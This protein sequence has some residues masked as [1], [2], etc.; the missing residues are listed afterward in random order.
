MERRKGRGQSCVCHMI[1]L[2]PNIPVHPRPLDWYI[3]IG[4]HID[5]ERHIVI[6]VQM[7]GVVSS[8]MSH[9]ITWTELCETKHS[10][11]LY[12]D[13]TVLCP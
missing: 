7:V 9:D 10:P 5:I 13:L 2:W 4:S 6:P 12:F 8:D 3:V 1:S 11:L